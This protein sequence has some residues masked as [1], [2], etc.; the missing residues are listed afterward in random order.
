M[1]QE[2]PTCAI[3]QSSVLNDSRYQES[4]VNIRSRVLEL[5]RVPAASLVPHPQNW[6]KHGKAQRAALEAILNEVGVADAVL[7]RQLPDGRLQILDGHLR[8]DVLKDAEVPVLVLDLNDEEAKKLLLTLDPLAAMA[9]ADSEQLD[10]LMREVSFDDAALNKL[11]GGLARDAGIELNEPLADEA[12]VD[13]PVEPVTQPGDL[14]LLDGHRLL[15][16]DSTKVE[17]VTRLMNGERAA[18]CASDPPYLVDYT[19]TDQPGSKTSNPATQNKNW[20]EYKDPLASVD[21]FYSYLK[22]ALDVALVGNPA[23]Y[24][25]HASRRQALVEQA[26]TKAGLLWHQ[27]I[28][29][30]K[31]RAVLTHSHFMWQFE[32][33]AYGWREGKPPVSRPAPNLTNVWSIAGESDGIHPTQKPLEIFGIPIRAHTQKNEIC[34][35]PFSGSGSQLVAAEKLERRCFAMESAPG[36]CDATVARFQRVFGKKAKNETRPAVE[37]K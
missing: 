11:I 20:D 16:G 4:F 35:E 19:A 30:V 26:W 29:W 9:G 1:S 27:S 15:C 36:Y 6:R 3:E 17:D 34:Y 22:V 8:S 31:P 32:P 5:R 12:A 10:A 24:Q 23:I 13:L 7:T 37:V 2:E 21:F 33:C 14:W 18:L 25:W 28:I